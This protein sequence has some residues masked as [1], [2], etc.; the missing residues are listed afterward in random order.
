M[1]SCDPIKI[2]N[3][4]FD[5]KQEKSIMANT[6]GSCNSFPSKFV[7]KRLCSSRGVWLTLGCFLLLAVLTT[8]ALGEDTNPP[9]FA[10]ASNSGAAFWE[11]SADSDQPTDYYYI[12]DL[13]SPVFGFRYYSGA[14]QWQ[15]G[16]GIYGDGSMLLQDEE[17]IVQPSPSGT[18][19]N[20][21]IYCQL[22]WKGTVP[23]PGIGLEIWGD[24]PG[25]TGGTEFPDTY[26][27]GDEDPAPISRNSFRRRMD[28]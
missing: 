7:S 8:V 24:A 20:I 23:D 14:W 17:S 19:S 3:F 27:E 2:V 15:S 21:T 4:S 5:K 1:I 9:G 26:I 11:F 12:P 25:W 16:G 6:I 10:G 28:A 22:T 13:A 18:G